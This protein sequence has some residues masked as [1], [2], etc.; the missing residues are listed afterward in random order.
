LLAPPLTLLLVLLGPSLDL[1]HRLLE[2]LL[3]KLRLVLQLELLP[4]LLSVS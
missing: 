2:V 3:S 1:L 4:E